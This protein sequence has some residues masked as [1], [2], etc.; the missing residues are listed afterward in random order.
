M[1]DDPRPDEHYG[2]TPER[3]REDR[4]P[5]PEP[6]TDPL[7]GVEYPIRPEDVLDREELHEYRQQRRR[8]SR[9]SFRR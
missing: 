3:F 6:Y 5:D 4:D 8:R 1:T 9:R 7:S 2:P